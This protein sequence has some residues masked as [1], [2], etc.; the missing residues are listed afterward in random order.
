[1]VIGLIGILEKTKDTERGGRERSF[2]LRLRKPEIRIFPIPKKII[3]R[4]LVF[5]NRAQSKT[6]AGGWS[7]L[8]PPEK[9]EDFVDE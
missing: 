6:H 8:D 3:P 9:I 4:I 2:R 7:V 5:G 1:M